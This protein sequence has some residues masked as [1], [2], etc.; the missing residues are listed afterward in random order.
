[1]SEPVDTLSFEEALAQLEDTVRR[2]ES[3]D[4]P[5]EE[6]LSLFERGVAL[7]RACGRRL[8]VAELRVQQLTVNKDGEASLAPFDGGVG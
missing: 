4:V 2:L 6:A 1:M 3:A 7:S 8:D 5:L